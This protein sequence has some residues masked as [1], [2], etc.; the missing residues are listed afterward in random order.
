MAHKGVQCLQL[1]ET[2]TSHFNT[3]VSRDRACE[4][5]KMFA[6][7]PNCHRS[8]YWE[9]NNERKES[10]AGIPATRKVPAQRHR[11][12]QGMGTAL[13]SST[14]VTW[15]GRGAPESLAHIQHQQEQAVSRQG[16]VPAKQTMMEDRNQKTEL[17]CFSTNPMLRSSCHN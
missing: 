4:T 15:Q 6:T 11:W 3:L 17:Y 10:R 5:N 7:L 14:P 16:E 2:F 1:P 12:H 13:C 8:E 9:K